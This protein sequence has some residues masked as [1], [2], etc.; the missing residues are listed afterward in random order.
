MTIDGIEVF[1]TDDDGLFTS[2]HAYW[3]DA[4]LT[5]GM[6]DA[7]PA[8]TDTSHRQVA[9]LIARYAE[10]IDGGDFDGLA[11][12]LG[13]AAVGA[14]DGTSLL[15]GKDALRDL[16][17]STTRLYPD[18]T[19]GTKHVTTNLIIDIDDEA[20]A[21]PRPG[22][23]GPSSRRCPGCP[24]SPFW[25]VATTIGSSAGRQAGGSPSAGTWSTWS[26]T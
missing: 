24:S 10:L 18:G 11:D 7:E 3:D 12:L 21:P 6:S 2:V 26:A 15:T 8:M 4:D 19:P 17:T 13:R 20:M 1:T 9:N 25:P 5:F 14:G 22:P 23:T 16:F